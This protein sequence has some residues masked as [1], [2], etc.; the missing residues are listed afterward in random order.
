MVLLKYNACPKVDNE[1][2]LLAHSTGNMLSIDKSYRHLLNIS[3]QRKV[4]RIQV[5][6]CTNVINHIL[7]R[8][9]SS[10]LY[11][12]NVV[13][14]SEI[15][16]KIKGGLVDKIIKEINDNSMKSKVSVD[17]NSIIGSL[18]SATIIEQNNNNDEMFWNWLETFKFF[19][20]I[21]YMPLFQ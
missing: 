12:N 16:C 15:Y 20:I 11:K 7:S 4:K 10:Y 19:M 3:I 21:S 9:R 13:I 17:I 14:N 1:G 18:T 5:Y 8:C 2:Q 6:W